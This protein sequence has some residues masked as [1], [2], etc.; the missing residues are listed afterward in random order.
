MPAAAGGGDVRS[1]SLEDCV[2]LALDRNADVVA[3]DA[4]VAQAEAAARGAE[5]RM[6][7]KLHV[8]AN[9]QQWNSPFDITFALAPNMAGTPFRVR[10]SFTWLGSAT[11]TQPLSGLWPIYENYKVQ[12]MGVDVA[13]VRREATKRDVA[14]QVTELYLRTLE[15]IRLS[16]VAAA[17]VDQLTAQLKQAQSLYTNGVVSKTD[18]LRAEVAL[19][20]A[21]QSVIRRRGQQAIAHARLAVAMG[22]PPAAAIEP[23]PLSGEPP[24]R[25]PMTFEE[26]ERRAVLGRVELREIDDQIAQADKAVRGAQARLLPDINAVSSYTHNEGS[27]FV[28]P[29]AVFVGAVASWDVWDWGATTQAIAEA[30]SRRQQLLAA[31]G[32]VDQIV[33]LDARQAYVDVD[34][35]ADAMDVATATVAAAEE[36]FRLVTKRYEAAAATA[37]D[38]VDAETQLTQAR[39]QMATS[40]YDYLIARAALERATGIA[41]HARRSVP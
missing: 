34:T 25:M 12:E 11:L 28:Q 4:E 8:D 35:T 7:P 39:G 37:F 20:G 27:E 32:K 36:N 38:V 24:A 29:N 5:G 18:V 6:G 15:A 3:Q 23:Q 33:R 31:K 9:F 14:F 41:P 10:D 22:M 17:S 30:K 2:A 40:L 26:V 16:E 1:L 19:A 13:K 21:R